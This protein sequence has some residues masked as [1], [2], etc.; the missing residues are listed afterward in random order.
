[1]W[2]CREASI[3]TKGVHSLCCPTQGF[4]VLAPGPTNGRGCRRP[5]KESCRNA[6]YVAIVLAPEE[7]TNKWGV[8]TSIF[9]SSLEPITFVKRLV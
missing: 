9:G 3:T 5:T 1:M 2:F 4:W 7:P 8:N 6:S